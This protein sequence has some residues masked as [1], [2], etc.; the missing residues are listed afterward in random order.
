MASALTIP[1]LV[2][3]GIFV[4]LT[5]MLLLFRLIGRFTMRRLEKYGIVE[6]AADAVWGPC[7]RLIIGSSRISGGLHRAAA[8]GQF[9]HIVPSAFSRFVGIPGASIPWGEFRPDSVAA[10][11]RHMGHELAQAQLTDG[12]KI[13]GPAWCFRLINAE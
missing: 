4:Q 6:P 9:L 1:V 8:D 10:A 12:T 7:S 3:G 2:L 13:I 11:G 5:F